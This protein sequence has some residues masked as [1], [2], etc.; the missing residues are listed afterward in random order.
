MRSLKIAHQSG[1]KILPRNGAGA[2]RKFSS[3]ALGKL[4]QS[5]EQVF[6]NHQDFRSIS[7][8]DFS[9]FCQPDFPA[10]SIEETEGEGPFEE[11]NMATHRGLGKEKIIGGSRK[12]LQGSHPAERLEMT[13]IDDEGGLLHHNPNSNTLILKSKK[14]QIVSLKFNSYNRFSSMGENAQPGRS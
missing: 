7:K 4:A 1:E 5:I 10:C 3:N 8:K 13:E 14:K 6:S 12:T 9:C 2:Q 11:E